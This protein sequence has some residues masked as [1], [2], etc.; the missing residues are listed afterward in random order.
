MRERRTA[1]ISVCAA[2]LLLAGACSYIEEHPQS[3]GAPIFAGTAGL[4]AGEAIGTTA[5]EAGL[6]GL[7]FALG[8]V[9][10][11]YLEKRDV[12]FFDKAIDRAAVA[13]PNAPV[14]W[15]NPN[16]GTSGTLVR[17]GD[18]DIATDLT[19]RKLRSEVRTSDELKVEQMVVCR[20]YD[21]TWYIQSS[22]LVEKKPIGQPPVG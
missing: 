17:E 20:P 22:W 9:A 5:A 16:T 3:F 10:G 12:V 11:P 18:V 19:C 15:N 7:G 21:G 13:P 2:L 8:V 1:S 14:N 4:M 6:G